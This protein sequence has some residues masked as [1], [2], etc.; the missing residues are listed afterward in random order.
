MMFRRPTFLSLIVLLCCWGGVR[1]AGQT[2][3]KDPLNDKEI[4]EMRDTADYPDKRIELMVKFAR[5]R[6]I[7][8]D[9]LRIDPTQG[10]D[11]PQQIHDRLQEFSTLVDEI[12][13]NIEMYAAHKTDMRKGL[14]LLIEADSEWQLKLRTL[15]EQTPP[16]E[17]DQF[18][19]VL[20]NTMDSVKD[21][22]ASARETLQAQVELAK[23]KKLNKIYSERAD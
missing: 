21:S 17:L 7:Q 16:E 2:R 4:D 23:E 14:K 11:R 9:N 13:D 20:A 19:F 8:I 22:A 3:D 12:D 15:K 10:K 6:M 1:A 5:A 18:S